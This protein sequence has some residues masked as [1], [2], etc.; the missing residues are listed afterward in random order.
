MQRIYTVV[1]IAAL[2]ACT[3]LQPGSARLVDIEQVNPNILLDIRYA[4]TDNFLN[5]AVYPSARCFLLEPVAMRLDSIQRELETRGLGLKI[6]DGYRPFSVTRKMWEILPDD[7]YVANPK[8]GSRHNRGA[9]VDVT[10]VD[11][12]GNEL[13]MPTV[14][15]DFS[16]KAGHDFMDLPQH[17][18]TNRSLLKE[19]MTKYGFM[20]IKTEWWHYDLK[21]YEQYP[22]LDKT[23]EEIDLENL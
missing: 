13:E 9:A 4:T 16:E 14:F 19:I 23:F 18:L 20:P 22:I 12:T 7:R 3:K 11:S 2:L 1:I 17:I 6:F 5:E 8:N 21:N 10:L 15:D